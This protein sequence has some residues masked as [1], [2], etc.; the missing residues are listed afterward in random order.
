MRS[1]WYLPDDPVLTST[2]WVE[3]EPLDPISPA[4]RSYEG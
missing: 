4:S 3:W 2:I 1:T